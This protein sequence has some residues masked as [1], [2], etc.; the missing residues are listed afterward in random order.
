MNFVFERFDVSTS[1]VFA[2][3][4]LYDDNKF[5]SDL[6]IDL[7][8]FEFYRYI[9]PVNLIT[10]NHIQIA[11]KNAKQDILSRKDEL[12]LETINHFDYI[13]K[14]I[15]S[16]LGRDVTYKDIIKLKLLE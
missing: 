12:I 3:G 11:I 1:S 8:T 6:S 10:R 2:L 9:G 5:V 4:K 16:V 15:S 7:E 13:L 14:N